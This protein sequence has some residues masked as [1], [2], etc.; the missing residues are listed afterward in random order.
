MYIVVNAYQ[1]L[2]TLAFSR[3][4]AEGRTRA[5]YG[6]SPPSSIAFVL[7]FAYTAVVGLFGRQSPHPLRRR[8]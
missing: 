1:S 7:L 6:C 5:M 8:L 4:D 3:A 2:I